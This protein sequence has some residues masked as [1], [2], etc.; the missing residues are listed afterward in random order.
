[1]SLVRLATVVAAHGIRGEVKLRVYLQN[2]KEIAKHV[3]TDKSGKPCKLSITGTQND[4]VIAKID[5]VTDRNQSELLK[6][7]DL[8]GASESLTPK[9]DDE[10]F[11]HELIGFSVLSEKG[12]VIGEVLGF[13]NF[14]AGD[15]VEIKTEGDELMLP[16]KKPFISRIDKK[17]GTITVILPDYLDTKS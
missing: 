14:G 3:L 11:E 5:G 2:P 17:A 16:F 1:V 4:I 15:I 9:K 8:F 6:G 12:E 13:Y 7:L 10:H